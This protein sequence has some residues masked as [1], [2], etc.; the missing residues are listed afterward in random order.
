MFVKET[1]DKKKNITDA[2]IIFLYQPVVWI[3]ETN[4]I[5]TE[6]KKFAL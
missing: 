5:K 4:W 1:A 2:Q 6:S 3:L